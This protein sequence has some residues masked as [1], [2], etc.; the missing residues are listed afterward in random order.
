MCPACLMTVTWAVVGKTSAGGLA[1]LIARNLWERRTEKI[2]H[3][4]ATHG[5]S[6]PTAKELEHA[7]EPIRVSR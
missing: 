3:D 5:T 4:A 1:A 6:V 2:S 7:T